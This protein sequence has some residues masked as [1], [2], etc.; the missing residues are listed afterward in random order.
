MD[1]VELV[2][3]IAEELPSPAVDDEDWRVEPATTTRDGQDEGVTL[4]E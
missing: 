1:D 3:E 4:Q 2:E